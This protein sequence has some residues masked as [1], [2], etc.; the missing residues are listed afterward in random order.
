MSTD[1]KVDLVVNTAL[2][3]C[4]EALE[5]ENAT[6]NKKLHDQKP[7]F[8]CIEDISH[9]DSLI[10][11]YTG[12]ARYVLFLSFFEFLGPEVN[13]LQYKGDQSTKRTRKRKISPMNQ[14]FMTLIKL[15]LNLKEKDIAFRFG[16]STSLVSRFFVTWV[17]FLYHHFREINWMPTPEQVRST[18]PAAFREKYPDTYGILDAT[19][20]FIETP[21]DLQTTWSNYK[22]HNTAKLLVMCTTN[23]AISFI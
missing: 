8:F 14:L 18:L 12:F 22:Y 10:Y 5:S 6:L 19:E 20:I 7:R 21:C 13:E 9:K 23:G 15:R 11:F 2:L 4:I 16:I 1:H 3:A 17:W